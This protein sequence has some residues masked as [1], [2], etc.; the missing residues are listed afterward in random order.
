MLSIRIAWVLLHTGQNLNSRSGHTLPTAVDP[1]ISLLKKYEKQTFLTNVV[2]KSER[3]KLKPLHLLPLPCSRGFFFSV[4]LRGK[5]VLIISSACCHA[6]KLTILCL[7]ICL[8]V[9]LFCFS[10]NP[11]AERG[12]TF[13]FSKESRCLKGWKS[14]FNFL[15][16]N[17]HFTR[18][19]RQKRH[20]DLYSCCSLMP[21][22]GRQSKIK[23]SVWRCYVLGSP[24]VDLI[25]QERRG[26]W[27]HNIKD[28]E[29]C[30]ENLIFS[31]QRAHV[32]S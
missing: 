8:V 30:S 2:V 4:V 31:W 5:L 27:T 24:T 25:S 7:F 10:F 28:A 12:K 13:G 32:T 18:K 21:W 20:R 22:N 26:I 1:H 23:I 16:G 3:T 11:G 14:S 29:N 9:V 6:T 19:W 17:T 15:S